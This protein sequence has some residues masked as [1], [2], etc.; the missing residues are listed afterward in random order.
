MYKLRTSAVI[1]SH[2]ADHELVI[3]DMAYTQPLEEPVVR[4]YRG[5]QQ[6]GFEPTIHHQ[7][8]PQTIS[9]KCLATSALTTRRTVDQNCREFK[10]YSSIVQNRKEF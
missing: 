2:P 4:Y 6:Q 9:P 8:L 3:L 7:V 1:R 5:W 10:R